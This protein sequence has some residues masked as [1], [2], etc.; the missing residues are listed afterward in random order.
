MHVDGAF[1]LW[2]ATSPS[3]RGLVDGFEEADSLAVD[4][5]KWLNVPYDSGIAIV[6]DPSH[7][8]ASLGATASY[9]PV[10]ADRE[11]SDFT[12]EMSRRA[13]AVP[14]YA[15]LRSL[16]R[17][18]LAEMIER[19]CAYARLLADAMVATPGA[20][21]LNVVVLNQVLIRF[22]DDDGITQATIE[23]VQRDGEAWLG[24]TRWRGR[25]AA[26]VSISN[27]STP[28]EDIERLADALTRAVND[29]R[30]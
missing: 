15:A 16:G 24:G 4:C 30:T 13:R 7:A 1:G 29:A 17:R 8:R 6:R 10:T 23:G 3:L 27:W 21:V 12:I 2:A 19:C 11:P 5:H 22:D 20:E 28:E 25:V 14:V 26:R 18:G 9:L